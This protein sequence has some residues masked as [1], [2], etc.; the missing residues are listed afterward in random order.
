MN[1]GQIQARLNN[2]L[3]EITSLSEVEFQVFSQWGDDGIIQY[4]VNN[5]DIPNKTF[6]EF[7]VENYRESNTRFLLINNNY[8]GLVIDGDKKNVDYINSDEL[9]W[10]YDLH[11]VHSFITRDNINSTILGFLNKGYNAEI[12]LLSIDIDGNDYWI[13]NDLAVVNPVIVIVEYN[14]VFGAS[15]K[16]TIPYKADF[17]GINEHPSRYY[18]GA[19]LNAFCDL[20]GK[21]GYS[22]IGCNSNGNNAYFIRNDKIKKFRPLTSEEAFI[23]AAFR[24]NADKDGNKY[25]G[26]ERFNLI[27]G[28]EIF[29]ISSNKTIII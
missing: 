11:A 3:N 24:L 13:W 22:L 15:N 7:G 1:L 6:I 9:S 5:I 19:S 25:T 16:W 21:K 28:T 8:S 4:L 27:R 14:S 20:A 2:Q 23:D 17:Y 12:A 18:W 10:S 26:K 29:D